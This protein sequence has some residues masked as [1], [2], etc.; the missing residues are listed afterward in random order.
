MNLKKDK[1]QD[2]QQKLQYAQEFVSTH[3]V[4]EIIEF[5]KHVNQIPD[6]ISFIIWKTQVDLYFK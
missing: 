1:I 3:S 2:Y 4:E 5:G 6:H